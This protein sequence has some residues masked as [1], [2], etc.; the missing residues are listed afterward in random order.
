MT[1]GRL[2]SER[3][4]PGRSLL[5][6][7]LSLHALGI[8][9]CA[10]LTL[11][12]ANALLQYRTRTITRNMLLEQ[13]AGI[14][15]GISAAPDGHLSIDYAQTPLAQRVSGVFVFAVLNGD[16]DIL[17]R[18]ADPAASRLVHLNRI[19]HVRFLTLSRSQPVLSTIIRPFR[20]GAHVYWLAVGWNLSAPG[21]V[22]D[23]I[24]RNFLWY[25]AAV[26]LLVL[27]AVLAIDLVI[28]RGV[29]A[30]LS[31]LAELVRRSA[32]ATGDDD[33]DRR[34]QT[35]ALP[36]EVVPLAAAYNDALDRVEAAYQLQRAFAAD[37]AHEL[38]TPLAVLRARLE[39]LPPDA[40][41]RVLLDDVSVM[42]RIVAQLLEIASLEQLV[43]DASASAD[44]VAACNAVIEALAPMAIAG[45]RDLGFAGGPPSPVRLRIRDQELFQVVR[46]LVENAINHTGPGTTIDVSVED[47]GAIVVRDDGPGIPEQWR[48]KV[49][50]RF[51]RKD[52]RDRSGAGLGLAIVQRIVLSHGGRIEL[53]SAEGE[54]ARFRVRLPAATQPHAAPV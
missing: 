44:P 36:S 46:N 8:A 45:G 41:R 25:S 47:D 35:E 13:S 17:L 54:G 43:V 24:L 15:G 30:P 11:G 51:W 18:S 28:M 26:A 37:A 9:A 52:R 5:A 33:R 48:K 34:L 39:M 20:L 50:E 38:R 10:L 4:L 16:G 14:I 42:T 2:L 32:S 29:L 49:F 1:R 27:L 12:S 22:F 3:L 7:V 31:H 6:R 23:N 19:A 40:A 53:D 21:V